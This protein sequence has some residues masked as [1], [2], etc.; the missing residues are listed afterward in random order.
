MLN[1]RVT[2]YDFLA[3]GDDDINV[4]LNPH[5]GHLTGARWA[6]LLTDSS[7]VR[8]YMPF[9]WLTL[10]A[11]FPVNGLDPFVYH[12]AAF[13]FYVVNVAL[14]YVLALLAIRH[15]VPA[16][17]GGVTAWHAWAAFLAAGWWAVHPLRV[18]S[19]A[20]ISGL[21]YGQAATGFL[22][23]LIAYLLAWA[24]PTRRLAWLAVSL[25]AIT[26][27]LMTYPIALG[28]PLLLVAV[29]LALWRGA[30]QRRVT[31]GRLAIEKVAFLGPV[32]AITLATTLARMHNPEIWGQA[33]TLAE[34]PPVDRFMQAAYVVAYYVWRP[35]YPFR[36]PPITSDLLGFDPGSAIFVVSAFL[37][38]LVTAWA[39]ARR[40]TAPWIAPVWLAYLATV[41]PFIGLTEH[42]YNASDRYAY[43]PSV[44][45]MTALAAGLAL[46]RTGLGRRAASG[47]MVGLLAVLALTT[48]RM[49]GIWSSPAAMYPY[50]AGSIPEGEEHDRIQSRLALYHYLFGDSATARRLIDRCLRDFPASVE[51]RKVQASIEGKTGRLAPVGERRPIAFMHYEMGLY[52]LREH[53]AMEARAQFERAL[54]LEPQLFAADF[55][56]AILDASAGRPREALHHCLLA[57]AHGGRGLPRSK[58]A[59]CLR[60]IEGAAEAGGDRRLAQ[61]VSVSLGREPN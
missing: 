21:L 43:L 27:S 9:G 4:T 7:Y 34:F 42:P 24:Y 5:L 38:F 44:V 53:E 1:I 37:V 49:L 58:R 28:F 41:G 29:D 6:W 16:A 46:V 25:V 26:A 59:D 19:T 48:N 15:F 30:A 39:I 55:D 11:L 50:L 61:A 2:G 36:L 51:M 22:L 14:A 31:L 54:L 52:F 40:R 32:A 20:W 57:Q 45:W 60:L 33:P 8:R 23:A 17:R 12:A 35:L 10:C 47:L 13:G 56:L 3:L 18:E